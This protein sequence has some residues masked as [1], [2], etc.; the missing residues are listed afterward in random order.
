M[1]EGKKT[2]VITVHLLEDDP[3]NQDVNGTE[4]EIN[5]MMSTIGGQGIQFEGTYYPPSAIKKVTYRLKT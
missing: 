2:F 3:I 1:S 4:D 5:E